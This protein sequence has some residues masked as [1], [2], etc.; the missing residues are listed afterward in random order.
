MGFGWGAAVT[1]NPL[2]RR[3]LRSTKEIEGFH[4]RGHREPQGTSRVHL[5]FLRK[6]AVTDCGRARCPPDSRRV[7]GATGFELETE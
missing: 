6:L 5:K 1:K 7:A 4:H 2:P 3:T